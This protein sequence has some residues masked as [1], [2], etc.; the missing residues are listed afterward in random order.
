MKLFNSI[1]NGAIRADIMLNRVNFPILAVILVL[2]IGSMTLFI[3]PLI[4]MANNGDFF[5]IISQNDLHY[6][7]NNPEDQQ[8]EH[9]KYFQKDYGINQYHS[10]NK[11]MLIST[12]SI[13]IKPA[14]MLNK[15]IT[16]NNKTFDIRFLSAILLVFHA[17]AAYIL[18]KVFTS[19]LRRPV[20]KLITT[21]LYIFIFMDTGYIAYFNSFYGEGVNIPF[22]LLSIGIL[23]Y[24]IRFNKFT[25]YNLITFFITSFIFFGA[26]QQLA[27]TGVLLGILMWRILHY[28]NKLSVKILSCI[29]AIAFVVGAG[30]FYKSIEG[31][32]DY[33]NRY[34][35]LNR[36]I[37][38][39]EGDADKILDDMNINDQYSLLENTIYFV[40]VPQ[41]DL[42]SKDLIKSYY[43]H[44][45]IDK[46]II[47]YAT[48]P[49][50]MFKMIDIGFR[51]AY[52][53]RPVTQGNYEKSAGMETG[54]KSYFFSG[55]ST[56]KSE[57]LPKTF[58]A[59][60]IYIILFFILSIKRYK[61]SRYKDND[62]G[63]LM[64]EAYVYIFLIGLVQIA[65]S[66]VG[67]GDADLSKHEFMYNMSW[68]IMF[69][70]FV[71]NL[72]K[73]K[74]IKEG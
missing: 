60:M 5:R 39:D 26:K 20:F 65:T 9:F 32:F 6:L 19:Y 73:K 27:P 48:H 15:L 17:I 49:K 33:I 68:D 31:D 40:D 52:Y 45:T 18:V 56:F 55:W 25:W 28:T 11:R 58:I 1:K 70:Y 53:I 30:F 23:L 21:L 44:F 34:H 29:M 72:L 38:L 42:K 66:L 47:Y 36:G 74:D 35:A 4:G 54:A 37:L 43:D 14:I 12:Q 63:R 22:F 61:L 57:Y 64:E 51:N 8:D 41:I 13:L 67:A 7:N 10:D 50:D 59:S 69:L 71:L 62:S 3:K 46:I 24:M 2:A 16:G